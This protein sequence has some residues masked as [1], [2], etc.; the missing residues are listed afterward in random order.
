MFDED[1]SVFFNANEFAVE[2]LIQ[3]QKVPGYLSHSYP[4]LQDHNAHAGHVNFLC[5]AKDIRFVSLGDSVLI[6]NHYYQIVGIQCD[7]TGLATLTLMCIE[8]LACK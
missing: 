1:L 2:A 4:T 3:E 8:Q 5:A 6:E 7:D